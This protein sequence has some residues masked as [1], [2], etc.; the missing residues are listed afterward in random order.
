[1]SMSGSLLRRRTLVHD[2]G[3]SVN[4]GQGH[5]DPTA[6]T[7][8][9]SQQFCHSHNGYRGGRDELTLEFGRCETGSGVPGHWIQK[10]S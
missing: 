3:R 8:S 2:R 5:A 1:M 7:E 9:G 10:G 6:R 4:L